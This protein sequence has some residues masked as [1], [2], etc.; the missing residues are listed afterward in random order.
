MDHQD[1]VVKKV[2]SDLRVTLAQEVKQDH[3]VL[4]VSRADMESQDFQDIPALL[5]R[6]VLVVQWEKEVEMVQRAKRGLP[7]LLGPV[8]VPAL[9]VSEENEVQKEDLALPVQKVIAV[10]LAQ[11]EQQEIQVLQEC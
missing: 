2:Q 5:V 8:A 7:A 3:L 9:P 10:I 4:E 6:K 1:P 11:Q